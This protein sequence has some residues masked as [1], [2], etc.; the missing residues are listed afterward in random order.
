MLGK[1]L[2]RTLCCLFVLTLACGA[3]YA[4]DLKVA[5]PPNHATFVAPYADRSLPP[6]N[7]TIFSNLSS[8]V[9]NLYNAAA[10]G[11]YVCG[12]NCADVLTDQWIAIPFTNK[13]ADHATQIQAAIGYVSGTKRVNLGIY[14]DNPGVGPGTLLGQGATTNIPTSGTCCT[15]ASVKVGGTTG[16]ALL[17]NTKYWIVATSDDTRAIDFEGIWQPTYQ[18]DIGADVSNAGWF[19]FSGLVPAAAVK[20]TNP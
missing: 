7:V 9:T 2:S 14:T 1:T 13:V 5:P 17:A 16:I 8:D 12:T 10:G 6:A 20:G 18:S 3:L 11:Y 15:L 19:T 4:S